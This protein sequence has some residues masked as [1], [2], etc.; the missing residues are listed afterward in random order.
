MGFYW[1]PLLRGARHVCMSVRRRGL[2]RGTAPVI[3][4]VDSGPFS[5]DMAS[6]LAG[7]PD[8]AFRDITLSHLTL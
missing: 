5:A 4:S 8:R 1:L 6:Q 7:S 3:R 2:S